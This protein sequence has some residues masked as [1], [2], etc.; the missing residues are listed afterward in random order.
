MG[1]I[2]L[3]GGSQVTLASIESWSQTCIAFGV[4]NLK[5]LYYFYV[6]AQELSTARAAK[7]LG[8]TSPAL[9]NQLK[10]LESVLG[11]RLT[12]RL[13][14]RVTMTECGEMVLTYVNRMFSLYDELQTRLLVDSASL[15]T[16]VRVGVCRDLGARFSL[17]LLFLLESVSTAFTKTTQI[18]FGSSDA[19]RSGFDSGEFDLVFGASSKPALSMEDFLF[20]ALEFP[21]RLFAPHHFSPSVDPF[22]YAKHMN[23]GLVMP[24]APSILRMDSEKYLKDQGIEFEHTIIC[25]SANAIVQL[26]ERG[27][28][29]GFVPTPCLLD[30]KSAKSLTSF[31]PKEGYWSHR[32][33]VL[34][35]KS[36]GPGINVIPSL[37]SLF[38]T[39]LEF[40]YLNTTFNL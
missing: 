21:V 17:D 32:V 39:D 3:E 7:R 6:F 30:F 4:L 40:K 8:I 19:L 10:H 22:E 34:V 18:I 33:S 35:R 20:Q 5:H 1:R 23:I 28:A 9:S 38:Q 25:N 36:I 12:R 27:A 14:G 15:G 11:V 13:E 24:M 26:I 29:F 2:C 31:G 16:T 37:A